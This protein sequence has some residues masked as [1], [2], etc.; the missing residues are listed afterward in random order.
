MKCVLIGTGYW[1]SILKGYLE[2]S[3]QFHLIGVYSRSSSDRSFEDFIQYTRPE[4]AFLCTPRTSHYHLAKHLLQNGIHVFCEKP[5]TGDIS[6]DQD[7][8]RIAKTHG[9]QL[10]VDYIYAYS[11]SVQRMCVLLPELGPLHGIR[12]QMTQFGK[13]YPDTD[14]LGNIGVHML[15]VLATIFHPHSSIS[16]VRKI[17]LQRDSLGNGLDV[18]YSFVMDGVPVSITLSLVTPGKSRQISIFGQ[19]G[20]LHFDM[21]AQHSLTLE[22]YQMDHGTVSAVHTMQEHFDES[23]NLRYSIQEFLRQIQE[24]GQHNAAT[25]LFVASAMESLEAHNGQL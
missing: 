11:K 1:G 9:A 20:A 23:N 12:M 21:M 24:G 18:L 4:A 5:L 25:C 14:I 15:T 7:L 22:R 13:F 2:E 3:K 17:T 8:Y 6:L 19:Q 10:F 16:H